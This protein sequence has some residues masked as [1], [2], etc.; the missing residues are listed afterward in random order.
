MS[1]PPFTKFSLV[2]S[3]ISYTRNTTSYVL[4]IMPASFGNTVSPSFIAS[5]T[6]PSD[7]ETQAS[8]LS[9]LSWMVQVIK[10]A[11]ATEEEIQMNLPNLKP[12]YADE[13]DVSFGK[14]EAPMTKPVMWVSKEAVDNYIKIYSKDPITAGKFIKHHADDGASLESDQVSQQSEHFSTQSAFD[15]IK[16]F[17]LAPCTATTV[18]Q[19]KHQG[20]EI[21]RLFGMSKDL[22]KYLALHRI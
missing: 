22:G 10:G 6:S 15:Q 8:L 3:T 20:Q 2:T 17:S 16:C 9:G 18:E 4:F 14:V 21:G 11:C 5:S 19:K 13:E 7:A 1:I 12:V